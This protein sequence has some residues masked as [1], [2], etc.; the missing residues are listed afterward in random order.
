MAKQNTE[1]NEKDTLPCG[2]SRSEISRFQ[3]HEI[4]DPTRYQQLRRHALECEHCVI[5]RESLFDLRMELRLALRDPLSLLSRPTGVPSPEKS[6]RAEPASITNAPANKVGGT[7]ANMKRPAYIAAAII[8]A[9]AGGLGVYL[10]YPKN[11]ETPEKIPLT[12][13]RG[14]DVAQD[15]LLLDDSLSVDTEYAPS[16]GSDD[17]DF[18][19]EF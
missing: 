12:E 16:S 8:F 6:F 14:D 17:F 11:P 5:Y 13:G 10:N 1:Q 15:F 19:Y 4:D 2:N 7:S 18:S 3:D 9:F